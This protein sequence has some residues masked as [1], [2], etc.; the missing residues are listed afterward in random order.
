MGI[1]YTTKD[2]SSQLELYDEKLLPYNCS[3]T[4]E[5]GA[6]RGSDC[7]NSSRKG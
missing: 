7:R 1:K 6:S 3:C 2:N 5:R 4:G